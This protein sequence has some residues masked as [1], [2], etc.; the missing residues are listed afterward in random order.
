VP[1]FE[2][3]DD[4]VLRKHVWVQVRP[5]QTAA[6]DVAFDHLMPDEVRIRDIPVREHALMHDV[7]DARLDRGI[8][9]G[10]A[11]RKHGD[12]VS[13]QK[14]DAVHSVQRVGKGAGVVEVET[15]RVPPCR[16]QFV[17]LPGFAGGVAHAHVPGFAV[18]LAEDELADLAR[19]P[20]DEH[21]RASVKVKRAVS[22]PGPRSDARPVRGRPNT[23]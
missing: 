6:L 12:G 11:L 21:D 8:D 18:E 13:G 3:L 16:A 20:D 14:V 17:D 4:R 2:W 19:R 7:A 15:H 9:E 10:L 22:R 1:R 5:L 23:A